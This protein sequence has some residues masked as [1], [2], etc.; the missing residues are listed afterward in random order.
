MKKLL[1][2]R[3]LV[4][5]IT[6]RFVSLPFGEVGGAYAQTTIAF[7]YDAAG[8]MIERKLQVLLSARVGDFAIDSIEIAPPL[9]F[10]VYPN[11][12][13]SFVNI[14]GELPPDVKEAEWQL[15]NNVGQ[16]LKTGS[17]NGVATQI[18]VQDLKAGVYPLVI[19]YS[20]K[21]RVTYKLIVSN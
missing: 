13:Q 10:K 14:E 15:Q 17:Y 5:V 16:V 12:A 4:F 7:T 18:N 3:H 19:I 6:L 2:I 21:Q 8:N 20:K 9:N 1:T 11:P